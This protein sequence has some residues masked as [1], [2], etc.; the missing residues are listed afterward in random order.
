MKDVGGYI[1]N[2]K[3]SLRWH[4]LFP[5]AA[6]LPPQNDILFCL[7]MKYTQTSIRHK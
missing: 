2:K 4:V 6:P 7:G 5:R 3:G 1:P